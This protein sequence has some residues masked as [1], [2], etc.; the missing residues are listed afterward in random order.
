M[1]TTTMDTFSPPP[2]VRNQNPL[3]PLTNNT[4][5]SVTAAAEWPNLASAWNAHIANIG[6]TAN[7][8]LLTPL[9]CLRAAHI[10]IALPTAAAE[11]EQQDDANR[12]IG[13]TYC[14][15]TA[16]DGPYAAAGI[17][18]C[19]RIVVVDAPCT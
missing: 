7:R 14:I 18:A 13:G 1:V 5:E 2:L 15:G 6:N 4:H 8:L 9:N 16:T 12:S 3:H 19:N 11:T 10:L 17:A